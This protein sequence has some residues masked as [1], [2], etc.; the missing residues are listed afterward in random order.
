MLFYGALCCQCRMSAFCM[1]LRERQERLLTPGST[2][3]DR[4]VT[5][6][7]WHVEDQSS[8]PA[9]RSEASQRGNELQQGTQSQ[10]KAQKHTHKGGRQIDASNVAAQ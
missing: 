7:A 6:P 4:C 1:E 5:Q 8:S 3:A 2:A 9:N 10:S